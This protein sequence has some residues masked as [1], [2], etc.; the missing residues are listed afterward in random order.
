MKLYLVSPCA[1]RV[2]RCIRLLY[3][4]AARRYGS[5]IESFSRIELVTPPSLDSRTTAP[6]HIKFYLRARPMCCIPFPIPP[7]REWLL[8]GHAEGTVGDRL[9]LAGRDR[10][11]LA[12]THQ[13]GAGAGGSSHQKYL[14]FAFWERPFGRAWR[15]SSWLSNALLK[16]GGNLC[17]AERSFPCSPT[18]VSPH[19]RLSRF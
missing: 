3:L 11:F 5:H 2:F 12:R 14:T 10:R 17:R 16:R 7:G 1:P 15:L 13:A 4:L 19:L 9:P 6:A 8:V 18:L